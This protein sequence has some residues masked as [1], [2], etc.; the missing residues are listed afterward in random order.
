MVLDTNILIAMLCPNDPMH[1]T[2]WSILHRIVENHEENHPIDFVVLESSVQEMQRVL[3]WSQDTIEKANLAW[4]DGRSLDVFKNR[5]VF[6]REYY[7]RRMWSSFDDYVQLIMERL[8]DLLNGKKPRLIT[9]ASRDI[10]LRVDK[11]TKRNDTMVAAGRF[12]ANKLGIGHSKRLEHDIALLHTTMQ[13]Q[14]QQEEESWLIWTYDLRL[15]IFADL[16][17]ATEFPPICYRLSILDYL[18][19]ACGERHDNAVMILSYIVQLFRED[20]LSQSTEDGNIEQALTLLNTTNIINEFDISALNPLLPCLV[21]PDEW[22]LR[23]TN[24]LNSAFAIGKDRLA[25]TNP[26]ILIRMLN[27]NLFEDH[28]LSLT[29]DLAMGVAAHGTTPIHREDVW[30]RDTYRDANI[31]GPTTLTKAYRVLMCGHIATHNDMPWALTTLED[32]LHPTHVIDYTEDASRYMWHLLTKPRGC[33]AL[34]IRFPHIEQGMAA[35]RQACDPLFVGGEREVLNSQASADELCELIC[36]MCITREH[37]EDMLYGF[38]AHLDDM[39]DDGWLDAILKQVLVV[40][41]TGWQT[42]MRPTWADL[43]APAWEAMHAWNLHPWLSESAA[44]FLVQHGVLGI[45]TD[46]PMLDCPLYLVNE[47]SPPLALAAKNKFECMQTRALATTAQPV[48]NMF[49]GNGLFMIESLSIPTEPVTS[50]Y[51]AKNLFQTEMVLSWLSTF[52]QVDCAIGN[53]IIRRPD[54]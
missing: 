10:R 19:H 25:P 50:W 6:I 8:T 7:K 28:Y 11:V 22:L 18:A 46:T 15:P 14:Q 45:A 5:P 36:N 44:S 42:M 21:S 34:F 27:D 53:V 54:R 43:R 1:T 9:A 32:P 26:D 40:V 3:Y 16:L 24:S 52:A 20:R 39:L 31:L 47:A 41:H 17:G 33:N 49:L 2:T 29:T 35:I 13:L 51:Q 38:K 12:V 30:T 48:H 37:F 23:E 4:L